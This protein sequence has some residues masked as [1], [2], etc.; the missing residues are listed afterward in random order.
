ICEFRGKL[1]GAPV[2]RF[3]GH[4]LKMIHLLTEILA[5][6]SSHTEASLPAQS[7]EL[8]IE[9]ACTMLS[10]DLHRPINLA[11]FCRQNGW[12]YEWFR[13]AFR[14]HTGT[15]PYH[16]RIQRK[17]DAA[18]LMLQEKQLSIAQ[19]AEELGFSSP[20]EFSALFKKHLSISPRAYR[21]RT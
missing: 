16:Y 5:Y 19:I 8:V 17:L 9:T 20:Q 7:P 13:K 21:N 11:Q 15:S 18:C 6:A 2:S 3:R 4:A 12:G 10:Q 1:T 14:R